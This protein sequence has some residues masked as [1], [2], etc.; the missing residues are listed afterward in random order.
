[1]IT[2]GSVHKL[3][4]SR[5]SPHGLY[6]A[7]SE[8]NE[9]L[10]PNKYVSLSDKPGDGKEV[11][12]YHD[13]ENRPVATTET[14]KA[15][16]GQT[17]MMQVMDKTIHGAFLDWGIEAK[18]LFLP[19]RNQVGAVEVGLWLPVYIYLDEKSGR[20]VATMHLKDYINNEGLDLKPGQQVEVFVALETPKGFRVVVNGRFWGML[21]HNQIFRPIAIGDKTTAYVMRITDDKRMDISLQKAGIDQLQR[22]AEIL[23]ALLEH[24]GGKLP[25]GDDSTPDQIAQVARMSKK[26]FKRT[27]GKLLKEGKVKIFPD[28]L[29]K[30]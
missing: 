9:I 11:F 16:V 20:A 28:R 13:S 2:A 14:P 5:I 19:N 22:S 27:A 25:I 6:L 7:D 30:I 12:V 24:H 23:L 3:T 15:V 8:E 4:V 26:L 17:A 10:L 21:Y 29:E 1:M 18:Q